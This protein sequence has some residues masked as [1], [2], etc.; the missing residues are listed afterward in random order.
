MEDRFNNFRVGELV[1]VGKMDEEKWEPSF[2]VEEC[3]IG[4]V[5]QTLSWAELHDTYL[6]Y[7]NGQERWQNQSLLRKIVIND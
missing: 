6:V 3:V 1:I 7:Y 4:V 2:K 5:Q